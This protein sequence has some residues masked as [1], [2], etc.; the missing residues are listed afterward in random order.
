MD[1]GNRGVIR[2]VRRGDGTEAGAAPGCTT[3]LYESRPREMSTTKQHLN[4]GRQYALC[5]RLRK[6]GSAHRNL[7][8]LAAV[9]AFHETS[10]S[11]RVVSEF[12][13]ICMAAGVPCY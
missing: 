1:D 13:I 4:A 3:T 10:G 6:K 9:S 2:Y 5:R 8:E 7:N 11:W 12:T